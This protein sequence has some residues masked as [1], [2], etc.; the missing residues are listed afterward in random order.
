MAKESPNKIFTAMYNRRRKLLDMLYTPSE[1]AETLGVQKSYVYK[2]LIPSGL[3][4]VVKDETG[5]V[6]V[7]GKSMS[8]YLRGVQTERREKRENITPLEENE[9]YCMRCRARKTV[10]DYVLATDPGGLAKIARCP[11]CGARMRKYISDEGE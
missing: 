11:E 3:V 2:T 1:L 10:S 8:N 7:S 5:H 4:E 6:F 9:F